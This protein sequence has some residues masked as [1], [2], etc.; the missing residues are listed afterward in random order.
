MLIHQTLVGPVSPTLVS[1]AIALCLGAPVALRT[2]LFLRQR[3]A[4]PEP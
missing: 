3:A 4:E 1:A 2:E